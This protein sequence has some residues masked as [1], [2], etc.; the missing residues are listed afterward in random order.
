M[1]QDLDVMK[2]R[3]FGNG[4]IRTNDTGRPDYEG[5]LSPLALEA[6]GEYML[7]HQTCADGTQRNSD[8]WQ[9]GMTKESYMKGLL[10]HAFHLWARLRGWPVR[11]PGAAPN[12]IEDCCAA[13][14]NI[15]GMLHEL[16]KE[17]D[18]AQNVAARLHNPDAWKS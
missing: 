3:D 17:R 2:M 15:Q 9:K 13:W 8:N 6:F 1:P 14:F 4:A 16:C 11:D 7:K 18:L 10:R 12:V 5:Y